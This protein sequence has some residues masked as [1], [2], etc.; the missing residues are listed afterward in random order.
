MI[1]EQSYDEILNQWFSHY[2]YGVDNGI[3]NM[4]AVTAQSNNDTKVWNTYDDWKTEDAITLT[5]ESAKEKT[6]SISSD[7]DA[8]GVNKDNWEE[9]FTGGSTASSAMYTMDVT[10]DT[11]LKGSV[12][13]NFQA[14]T[15]NGAM[16]ETPRGESRSAVDHDSAVDPAALDHDNYVGAAATGETVDTP[17]ASLINRDGLMVSAMLVDIAP[18]GETFPAFNTAPTYVEKTILAKDGAWMGGGLENLDLVELKPTD[19]SYKIVARG[20]MDLCNPGAGYDSASAQNK[21]KLVEGKYYDYTLYLQPNLYEVEAGHRLALVIYAYEPGKAT[22]AQNYTITVDNASVSAEIPVEKAPSN[23]TGLPYTDV[24][25]DSWYYEAV[26][27]VTDQGI[28]NGTTPTTFSPMTTTSRAMIVTMLWRMEGSPVVNYRMDF[29]DVK[30]DAYYAEAVRWA[31][32]EGIVDGYEDGT[33]GPDKTV[34]REQMATILYRYAQEKQ[35]DV[36]GRNDLSAFADAARVSAYAKEAM[37][38]AVDAGL[39]S[40]IG[41]N[42][43]PQNGANR[44]QVATMLMRFAENVNQ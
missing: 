33:F 18:E 11:V 10:A 30:E 35:Y 14:A 16:V 13:V 3:E 9:V 36:S 42:L 19:V 24:A 2:L 6:A 38:W 25:A 44:A 39:I 8:I 40:G 27:Y 5:G 7:Y 43:V 31:A 21:V 32:S 1:G 15:T 29:T 23:P 41:D 12:A 17:E 34:T 4:P 37:Q 26:K 28:M 20:W 22:Y